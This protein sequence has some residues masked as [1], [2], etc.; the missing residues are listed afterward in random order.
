[1]SKYENKKNNEKFVKF[2]IR[3]LNE[4]NNG[5]DLPDIDRKEMYEILKE[6]SGGNMPAPMIVKVKYSSFLQHITGKDEEEMYMNHGAPFAFLLES[7]LETYSKLEIN[8]GPGKL[9]F[10]VNGKPPQVLEPLLDG[11]E[12]RFFSIGEFSDLEYE[13][14]D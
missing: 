14:F 11:D 7:V 5:E 2:D 6:A 3:M 13:N 1:M 8:Y 12:I 9:C 4:D 10:Q